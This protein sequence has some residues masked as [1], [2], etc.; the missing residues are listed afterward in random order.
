MSAHMIEILTQ[1][2]RIETRDHGVIA[3]LFLE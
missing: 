3:V 1:G 2:M